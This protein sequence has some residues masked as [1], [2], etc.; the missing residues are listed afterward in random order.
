[1]HKDLLLMDLEV[2]SALWY[3][4]VLVAGLVTGLV[5]AWL[6]RRRDRSE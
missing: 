6:R 5:I 3:I 2:G 4:A 1:M